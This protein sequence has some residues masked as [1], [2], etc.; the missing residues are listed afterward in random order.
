MIKTDSKIKHTLNRIPLINFSLIFWKTLLCFMNVKEISFFKEMGFLMDRNFSMEILQMAK[1]DNFMLEEKM[2]KWLIILCLLAGYTQASENQSS[3][4]IAIDF[5]ES[6]HI[7]IPQNDE[8]HNA[9]LRTY[10]R[11]ELEKVTTDNN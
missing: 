1:L 4:T 9:D 5:I 6:V 8:F 11:K 3:A 7:L 2:W 10:S